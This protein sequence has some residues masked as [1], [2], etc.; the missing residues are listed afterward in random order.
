MPK[1]AWLIG[2]S[3]GIGA[4]L[5]NALA[6]EG[7]RVVISARRSASDVRA[8]FPALIDYLPLDVLDA[9]ACRQVAL[10]TERILGNAPDLVLYAAGAWQPMGVADFDAVTAARLMAVN[11]MGAV[12]VLAAVLPGARARRSGHI[13]V[14]AS[15]AGYRGLPHAAAYGPTKAALIN[16][17]ESLAPELSREGVRL[18]LVNPG[19]VATPMT[20]INDFPMPFL[21][22][23]DNAARRL[24]DALA[25]S[26]RFEI[27][28]PKR[29]TWWL[30][31]LRLLPYGAYL[32]LMRHVVRRRSRG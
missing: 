19:F 16:L 29:F 28:F 23:A 30:K 14:I 18:R 3:T 32:A 6:A 8:Q 24:V 2:A 4:A 26:N 9:D 21:L 15:V 31:L 1:T 5:A 7:C 11:Y 25:R 22:T 10:R 27:T 13:A 17:C 20:A 12:N